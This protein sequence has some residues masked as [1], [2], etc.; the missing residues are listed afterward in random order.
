MTE[1]EEMDPNLVRSTGLEPKSQQVGCREL[2]QLPNVRNGPTTRREDRHLLPISR[3]PS[4]RAID[5]H[6][7]FGQMPPAHAEIAPTYAPCRD[8]RRQRAMCAVVFR[9]HHQ[10]AR[11]SVETVDDSGSK[12]QANG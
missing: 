11:V 10:A 6:A 5:A 1:I 4:D 9:D 7:F 3:V 2:L 12:G 8:G